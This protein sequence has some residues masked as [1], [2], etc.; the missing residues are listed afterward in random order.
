MRRETYEGLIVLAVWLA[1]AGCICLGIGV[2]LRCIE[3]ERGKPANR[4][5]HATMHSEGS[6]VKDTGEPDRV[7]EVLHQHGA[8]ATAVVAEAGEGA[9]LVWE[10]RRHSDDRVRHTRKLAHTSHWSA[11]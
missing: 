11:P 8:T 6:T 2:V 5:V 7:G 9:E 4:W 3:D 1:I 10:V